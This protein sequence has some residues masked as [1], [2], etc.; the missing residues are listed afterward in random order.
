M[1]YKCKLCSAIYAEIED[2]IDCC[3]PELVHS[4]SCECQ[5]C[6]GKI[7]FVE[8]LT[9][10]YELPELERKI[11]AIVENV[12]SNAHIV[13]TQTSWGGRV[14]VPLQDNEETEKAVSVAVKSV[15]E[16][17]DWEHGKII[18]RTKTPVYAGTECEE[19]KRR[20]DIFSKIYSRYLAEKR[21][22]KSPGFAEFVRKLMQEYEKKEA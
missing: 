4:Y 20:A 17:F 3:N 22:G 16:G 19:N 9:P 11:R 14:T 8:E 7:V 5:D 18:L 12:L 6:R 15:M 21:D 13:V 2:A 10:A 1:K